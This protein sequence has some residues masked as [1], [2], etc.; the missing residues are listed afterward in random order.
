MESGER[1]P[2]VEPTTGGR[3]PFASREIALLG[4]MAA[5]W[6]VIE[7]TVGGMIKSWHVPFGGSFLSTFGVVILLTARANVPRRWSSILVGL[8][9]A[10]I[11]FVSGFGGAAFAAL[12]IAAEALIV[13]LVLSFMPPRQRSRLVAGA[14]AVLW[15]LAHPFVVQGYL[16]GYGPAGVFRFTVGFI[17]NQE[18]PGSTQAVL[19]FIFLVIVHIAL[20]VSAVMFVDRILL[21]PG[22][23]ARRAETGSRG[24][25]RGG[26]TPPGGSALGLLIAGILLVT[27]VAPACAQQTDP[28]RIHSEGGSQDLYYKLPELTVYGTRLFGPYSV[29]QLSSSDI[30]DAGAEDL[31]QALEMV[32]GVVVRTNSRGESKLSTRGLAE[33]EI[34]VLVDGVPI[35]D[36]YTG[37]VNSSMVLA[38]AL[39]SVR[40]TKGPAASVYGAN[41][42]GGIVEVTTVTDDRTGMGYRLSAGDGGR[43]A[44]YVSG[45]G[46]IGV[47]HLAGGVA[48]NGRSGF[49]LPG[50]YEAEAWEDGGTRDH[51]G[52]EDLLVWGRAAW[53][54]GPRTDASVS[55]Q[56]GDGRRDAPAS[57]SS[58]RPRFWRFPFWREVRTIGSVAFRPS[59]ALFVETKVYYG[60]NDNQLAA[61]N[62]FERTDRRWL[63]TVSNRAFGGYAYSE[64]RGID[65]H[66]LS[67][68]MNVR[69][70]IARLQGDVGE[71]WRRYEATTSS[72]YGQDVITITD[73]DRLALAVNTDL[74]SGEGR[75]LLRFNPQA[76][77]THRM[78]DGLS[79][80]LLAGMKTRF[81][82]LKEWFSTEI[83]NPDLRPERSTS[84]EVELAKRTAE[85]SRVSVLGFKQSVEDM[86]VAGGWGAP[87]ENIGTVSSW[88]AEFGVEH[89][90]ARG[91]DVRMSLAMTS[92]RD[93]E[94]NEFV[95]LVPR[96]MAVLE[97]SYE[98]GP[99]T[100]L[101]RMTRVGSRYDDGYGTLDPYYLVDARAT[102]ATAWGDV[103]VGVDNVFDALYEDEDGFPQP[104]RSY[105][106]GIARELYR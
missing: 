43:Y 3:A 19:V 99:G 89:S 91:L 56:V 88:G 72:L 85:G 49:G 62:D 38:G 78:G 28:S 54:M 17:A 47:V 33:R 71:D 59:D 64:F 83:G 103:F 7:I 69:G 60:T 104:G 102:F 45:G 55:V 80:R 41:A 81:P 96:T 65:G 79:V 67:G 27:A 9:A 94:T 57:T 52:K 51:S 70:D 90:L 68:G 24:S 73:A 12:G 14:L 18:T 53:K 87:A 15:A 44:G 77:W 11:R 82:T 6:G 101:A 61:Y 93:I 105:E 10:G 58:D 66:R 37:S 22:A 97:T 2:K 50:S 16:A 26:S 23:R 75:A 4:L 25:G 36:P 84:V 76:A 95:P 74:M 21:A 106:I 8:A 86:I 31:S 63:S 48:A 29:F 46:R 32:P 5:L 40:V 35:S 39:G 30:E 1:G 13:E 34:V 20:G 100:Y 92:A 42:L 98:R